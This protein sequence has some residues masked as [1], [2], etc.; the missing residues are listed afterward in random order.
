[1][2][3]T[4]PGATKGLW[5]LPDRFR[6]R[7]D[8]EFWIITGIESDFGLGSSLCEFFKTIPVALKQ[9]NAV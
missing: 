8:W 1:M 4:F 9:L 2:Q 5:L 6:C 7:E 3:L